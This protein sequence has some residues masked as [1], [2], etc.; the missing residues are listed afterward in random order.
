[1]RT[2][3]TTQSPASRRL[4]SS[5]IL[6]L[7]HQEVELFPSFS[8]CAALVWLGPVKC[9]GS[10]LCVRHAWSHGFPHFLSPAGCAGSGGQPSCRS[11]ITPRTSPAP[12]E[13]TCL[14]MEDPSLN[15]QK[16][17]LANLVQ[18]SCR[19]DCDQNPIRSPIQS[20][21]SVTSYPPCSLMADGLHSSSVLGSTFSSAHL[22]WNTTV[23]GQEVSLIMVQGL[24]L[25]G[26]LPVAIIRKINN[27][28][29]FSGRRLPTEHALSSN[30]CEIQVV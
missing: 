16:D 6:P 12:E 28:C 30:F 25:H 23:P 18:N 5:G 4:F 17:R 22:C 21:D 26:L 1:M 29:V 20:Q 2:E 15:E 11:L 19:E 13:A 8:I 14:L 9:G 3:K 24:V 10:V 27:P 7:L